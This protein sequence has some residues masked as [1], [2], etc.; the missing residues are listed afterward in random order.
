M[1]RQDTAE[2]SDQPESTY[3]KARENRVEP[4]PVEPYDKVWG[5]DHFGIRS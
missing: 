1:N 2:P 4:L 3:T 5:G